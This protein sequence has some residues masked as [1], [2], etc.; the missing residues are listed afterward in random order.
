MI[1]KNYSNPFSSLTS[2]IIMVLFFVALFYIARAAFWVL[3][4]LA[5]ILLIATLIIDHKVVVNYGK[6]II[7]KLKTNTLFGIAMVLLTIFGA[8]VVA[9]FLFGKALLKRKFNKVKE[10]MEMQQGGVRRGEFIEYEEVPEEPPLTLELPELG[11]RKE[12]LRNQRND[13]DDMFK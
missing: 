8:P 13:Y 7:S 1:Q 3:S 12:P 2:L 9:G 6:W 11:R 10:E 4:M 5:P